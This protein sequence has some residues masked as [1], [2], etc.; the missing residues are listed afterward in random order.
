[1][2]HLN[3]SVVGVSEKNG[4]EAAISSEVTTKCSTLEKR[5]EMEWA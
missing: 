1:M 2:K 3:I 5:E 4:L